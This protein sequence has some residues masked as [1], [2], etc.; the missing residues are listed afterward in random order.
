MCRSMLALGLVLAAL[1]GCDSDDG[2]NQR[3]EPAQPG[4]Q[5]VRDQDAARP[6]PG[7]SAAPRQLRRAHLP[8]L[9]AWRLAPLRGPARGDDRDRARP[10]EAGPALPRHL[11]PRLDRRRGGPALDGLRAQ[12]QGVRDLL[13][14]LHRSAGLHPDRSVPALLRSQPGRPEFAPLGDPGA[15][16]PHQPQGRP[17]RVRAGRHALRRLRRRRLRRRPRRERPEPRPHPR[18]ADQDRPASRR[19][20]RHPALQ[21]VRQPRRR[22]GRDLRLRAAQPL[23][24]LVRPQARV[25][26]DRRR[27]PGR[28]G[29]DRLRA[30]PGGG[31]QPR[32]GYNFGW[33]SFEG[34]DRYEPAAPR[35]T[36]GP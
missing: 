10:Q 4:A 9:S 35:G 2:D 27:G 22:P 13:R 32:G 1:T 19:R 12:L 28:G 29:G 31:R 34:D 5:R 30:Q 18:Q 25:A 16:L 7:A 24:L 11:G 6:R 14:V 23:P 36:Y 26:R 15:P 17:A 8:R 33:D 20:L 21:P 3:A